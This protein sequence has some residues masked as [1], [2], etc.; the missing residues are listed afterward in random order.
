MLEPRLYRAT[1]ILGVAAAIVLMFSVAS[2]PEALRTETAA[3]AFDGEA[4]A[5]L[6][7]QIVQLAPQRAPGSV[8]DGA[9]ADLVA[10]RF[11]AIEGGQTTEQRFE[12]RF[13]GEEVDLRNVIFVRPGSAGGRI[14]LAASR[15]CAEGT[16]AASSAAATATLVGL[17]ETFGGARHRKTL[18][19]ASL[20]GSAAG[21][22]G[23]SELGE[24]LEEERAKAVIV[25]SQPGAARLRRP[26]VIP[27]SS[28]PQ[29]TS[30]Q[31]IESAK[32]AV[33]TELPG[34][35][36]LRLGTV[37]SLLRLAIPTGLGDQAPLVESGADAIAISSAGE[38]PLPPS[39]DTP[40]A[41]STDSLTGTGRAILSLTLAL[42]AHDGDLEHGPD[43][44]IPLAGKLIPGW[45]LALLAAA[46]LVPIGLISIDALLRSARHREPAL[47]GLG[48]ALSRVMPFAFAIL[49]AY[50]L[51]LLGLMPDPA[52]PFDPRRHTLDL[53]AVLVLALL[54]AVFAAGL[55][56]LRLLPAPEHADWAV[57]ASIGLILFLASVGLW[58]ANPYLALLLVPTVHL[59]FFATLLRGR[60]AAALALSAAGLVIP[61]ALLIH[62]AATLGVGI[63]APWELLL[64]FTGQH[65]GVLAALPLCLLGG[66]LVAILSNARGRPLG[67]AE[68]RLRGLGYAGPGSLGGTQSALPRR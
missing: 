52:F 64:M 23:A 66:C 51:A 29:S 42:D 53:E 19:F 45:T 9:V 30:I 10:A 5:G 61:L 50:L 24:A 17:A 34:A 67:G 40:A 15:D 60:L 18:V 21:A 31:L 38:R 14:V 26:L 37:Q 28:G 3:D 6:A 22:A 54:A 39:E 11:A 33:E 36:T 44:Y 48:W 16:C 65:F 62:L 59:W 7:R 46:L 49:V 35:G 43:A 41:L 4:A 13:D 2:R 68:A 63:S 12:G 58:L 25:I 20:D 47:A 55:R 57:P 32:Q 1:L 27:W 8:G 56:L